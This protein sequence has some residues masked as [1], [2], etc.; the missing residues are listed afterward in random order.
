MAIETT[1]GII[2]D[3]EATEMM[4]KLARWAGSKVSDAPPVD[5]GIIDLMRLHDSA[6]RTWIRQSGGMNMP[7]ED[8]VEGSPQ[9]A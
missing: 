6:W 3:E 7:E 9:S 2:S 1:S 8:I 4:C 5:A